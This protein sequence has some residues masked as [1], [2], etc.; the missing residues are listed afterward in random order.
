MEL[1]TDR[2]SRLLYA[3]DASMYEELPS[4]VCFP[5]SEDEF[6]DL[7][8]RAQHENTS[9]LARAAGTSLAGQTTT[10]GIVADVGRHMNG[11][12]ELDLE[13]QQV[14]VQPGII[15]DELN[16]RLAPSGLFFAPDTSTTNRCMIG[17]MIGN[18]SCG[19]FSIKYGTTRDHVAALRVVLSDGSVVNFEPWT[20]EQLDSIRRENNLLAHITNGMIALVEK[21][22]HLIT[23]RFPG[24]D[25]LRK[26]AG[27]ALD[28]LLSMQPFSPK[29][30]RFNL[31]EFLCGSEGTLAL[32]SEATLK[33]LPLPTKK[34]V[35]LAEFDSLHKAM[36]S[37]VET[38]KHNPSAVELID[39]H[40]LDATKGN[41][42]QAENRSVLKSDPK[43]VLIIQFDGQNETEVLESARALST[44]LNAPAFGAKLSLLSDP[45]EQGKIWELRKAGLGLLMGL[46]EEARSPSFCED[47]AVPVA[48]L[49]EY[50]HNFQELLR[51]YETTAVFYAHASVGELHLRPI[52]NTK[53]ASGL[54]KMERFARDVALLVK[55]YGGTISGE[56]GDGRARSPFITEVMGKEMVEVFGQVKSLWDPQNIF[57]PGKIVNPKPFTQN[58][59]F[60]P[61]YKPA[62]AKTQFFWRKEGGFASALEQCNGAGVCRK[63]PE[64][65]GVMCPSYMATRNE[66]DSTRGRANVFRHVFTGANPAEFSSAELK[67]ALDLCLSC[68][69]CKS[70]CPANV[71]MARMKAE[72]VHGWRERFGSTFRERFFGNPLRVYHLIDRLPGAKSSWAQNLAN[73]AF[74]KRFLGIAKVRSLPRFAPKRAR[75]SLR[76]HFVP[77]R[78]ADVLLYID[79]FV[80]YHEP[81]VARDALNV[82]HALDLKVGLAPFEQS[83]RTHFSK[84]DLNGAR[85][86]ME[87]N[88]AAFGEIEHLST[89]IVGLEPSEI[90]TFGDEYLDLCG[91]TDLP[92]A[93]RL[94][95]RSMLF[96]AFLLDRLD[97]SSLLHRFALDGTQSVMLHNHCHAKALYKAA[98]TGKLL[99]K[100]G[101]DVQELDAGCCGMAG[102]FGYEAEHSA[103]SLEIGEQ[104]LFPA[105]RESV[106]EAIVAHGFSCRHQIWDGVQRQALHPVSLVA[107]YLR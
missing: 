46:G 55:R 91:E 104:R 107:G 9:I 8:N 37:T 57:N 71:D 61:K 86:V 48:R 95:D 83:G 34:Q 23:E 44:H 32:V 76:S 73:S 1:K 53:T 30:R 75:K 35:V 24:E 12:V 65:G 63:L 21:H 13:R 60:S 36:I 99:T 98:E 78:E 85:R 6:I 16:R 96:E 67:E 7:V 77:A 15:R 74:F 28:R 17:G 11:F 22:T 62:T 52:I 39:H 69:A 66:K 19:S 58:L 94:A 31:A 26:N 3:S 56:H 82:L 14:R 79:L 50:V 90:L 10:D 29:G 68:K 25:V 27:Y 80:D 84:G 4:A 106:G 103:L 20:P 93:Q 41:A 18:N 72:F 92:I 88:L 5:R 81:H 101:F 70:E 38:V 59:R 102:S 64:S 49:P 47:T 97:D 105:L 87:A 51:H 2:L 43:F 33:L 40:I 89:P 100:L 54:E 45:V 42:E